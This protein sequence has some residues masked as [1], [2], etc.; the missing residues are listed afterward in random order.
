MHEFC[1][2]HLI[3]VRDSKCRDVFARH[4]PAA[5]VQAMA[6][7]HG[8]GV[9]EVATNLTG[10]D[11]TSAHSSSSSSSSGGGSS[12]S[13]AA[14]PHTAAAAAGAP[15]RGADTQQ[16][17]AAIA[18]AAAQHGLPPPGPGY[19]TNKLP[20]ELIEAARQAGLQ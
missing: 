8:P 16:V 6:L 10:M 20:A 9:V 5:A 19:V 13:M 14:E 3:A 12:S 1:S 15:G 2:G 11:W 7:H 17:M 18:A 4:V